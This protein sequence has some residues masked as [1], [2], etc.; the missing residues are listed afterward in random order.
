MTGI[1]LTIHVIVCVLL[2]LIVLLQGGKAAT[3]GSSFGGGGGQALFG[4]TGPATIL[5]KITTVVA[6]VFMVTSLSLAYMSVHKN[7]TSVMVDNQP[8]VE[9]NTD[10]EKKADNNKTSE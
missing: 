6:I 10:T 3:M 8:V 2:V 5:T 9:Q 4:P 7:S 1:I